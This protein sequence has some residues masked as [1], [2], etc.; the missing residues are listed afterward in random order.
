LNK[1]KD[2]LEAA[3]DGVR[4]VMPGVLSSFFTTAMVVGPLAFLSG[5][6]GDVLK[7]IPA[8]LLITLV[9]S[10]IEAFLILPAHLHHSMKHINQECRSR[11]QKKFEQGFE[12][13]RDSVFLPIVDKVTKSPQLA[14]GIMISLVLMSFA[15]IPAGILKYQ[16]FP[17]LESDVIQAR[18]ILPQGTP[19]SRT[20]ELVSQLVGA[21]HTLD[22]EFTT[23][24][25]K[26]QTLLQNVSVLFNVNVDAHESGPHVATVSADLLPAGTRNGTVDEMLSRWRI[27]VG[28]LPDVIALKFT[29][30]ERGIA[31]KAVDLQIQGRN[32]ETLK[33]ASVEIQTFLASIDGITDISDDLRPG[34]PEFRVHL[35]ETAGVFGITAQAVANELR[36]AIY[37]KTTG[38][39]YCVVM[40]PMK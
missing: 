30:K 14:I 10:L 12:W 40:K 3:I 33:A 25:P 29:D 28:E 4:Q 21:L 24:Q 7:Y 2:S 34:K 19:L 35:K 6:M 18:I 16:A 17:D 37:G 39:K 8:V 15:V 27:L 13:V 20:E 9:I 23:R 22:K 11:F 1:G 38:R 32:L 36:M 26:G 5:K 31:G